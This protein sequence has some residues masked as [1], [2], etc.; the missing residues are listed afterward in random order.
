MNIKIKKVVFVNPFP[1]YTPGINEATVYPP[2][3]I[4]YLAAV[5]EK[6]DIEVKIID[7]NIFTLTNKEVFKQIKNFNPEIIGITSHIISARAARELG[8]FLRK[9]FPNKIII[10]GGPYATS[11]PD[12]ILKEAKADF[13]VKGEGELT[14]VDLIE[15]IDNAESV[16]GISYWKNNKIIHNPPRE[17]IEDLDTVP[18][19]AYHLLPEF[20]YYHSRSRRTP[21]A[22]LL[23][24]RGCP[25]QCIYCNSNIFGKRFRPRSVSN[26]LYEVELL[27]GRYKVKQIDIIDDNFTLDIARAE[28]F[29][30]EIIKRKIKLSFNFQSG[31]RA[32]RVTPVLAR[33]MKKAGVYKTLIGVESGDLRI[34]K[35][36]KKSLDLRKVVRTVKLL[37]KHGI[38]VICSFIIGLPEETRESLQKTIDFAVKVNPHI[39]NFERAVPFPQT[40][41]YKMVK[42]KGRFT[43]KIDYGTNTGYFSNKFSYEIGI[44]NQA[45][46]NEFLARAFRQFYFRPSKAFDMIFSI[47]SIGELRW[48]IKSFAEIFGVFG[49]QIVSGF[50]TRISDS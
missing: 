50:R 42:E 8:V 36:I 47:R 26:I 18:F 32:D 19:P 1:Y 5:L 44:V 34:Q 7:A 24:S 4:T 25:F 29:F 10:F 14:I 2:L 45:L 21:I 39:A 22:T 15:N 49:K 11:Q 38:I 20:K 9:K 23:G 48:T 3:G 40:E 33:K 37:R 12:I 30:D 43:E 35:L 41:L 27:V 13:V 28:K 17:L 46:V 31:M 16:K 6:R